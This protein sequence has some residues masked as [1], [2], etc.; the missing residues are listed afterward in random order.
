[1]YSHGQSKTTNLG[2]VTKVFLVTTWH[3]R[4]EAGAQRGSNDTKII[5]FGQADCLEMGILCCRRGKILAEPLN[6]FPWFLD[7]AQ[8]IPFEKYYLVTKFDIF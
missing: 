7:S 5:A 3:V 8:L 1:M 4:N 6:L 2:G